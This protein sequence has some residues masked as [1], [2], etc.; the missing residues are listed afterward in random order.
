M[1]SS[2]SMTPQYATV[3]FTDVWDDVSEFLADYANIGIPTTIDS[4]TSAT[5]LFYLL[6]AKYG[7]TPIANNDITQ[8]KYKIFSIIFQY[9]PTWEKK[10]DIQEIIRGLQESDLLAGSKAVYN[11]ALNPSTAPSTGTLEELSYINSQNTTN[12]KRSK[13]EAYGMLWEMLD[14][15]LTAKFIEKFAV[16]F[17]KFVYPEQPLLY[18]TDTEEDED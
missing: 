4:D 14:D 1:N 16:C 9:G 12:L 8:F 11:T 18:I 6:Y 7:N 10:L 15:S 5:T 3:L 13:L 2:I 17:K